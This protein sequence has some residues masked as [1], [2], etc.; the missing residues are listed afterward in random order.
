MIPSRNASS[1]TA[2]LVWSR[3]EERRDPH[4]VPP[5]S[6]KCLLFTA[7]TTPPE[8]QAGRAQGEMAGC[9][10]QGW[11]GGLHRLLIALAGPLTWQASQ[12]AVES[13]LLIPLTTGRRCSVDHSVLLGRRMAKTQGNSADALCAC[14]NHGG[15]HWRL[16]P[17]ASFFVSAARSVGAIAAS[18][19]RLRE[20]VVAISAVLTLVGRMLECDSAAVRRLPNLRP[21]DWHR[22]L[23]VCALEA[24]RTGHRRRQPTRVQPGHPSKQ[25]RC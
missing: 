12:H 23:W 15:V 20:G 25:G 9:R 8:P 16:L 19:P 24:E 13:P 21:T 3:I 5:T 22:A 17:R 1:A 4:C 18:R 2:V 6:R 7:A 14:D 11:C 10:A